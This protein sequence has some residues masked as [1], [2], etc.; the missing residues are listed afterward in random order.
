MR[1]RALLHETETFRE[2]AGDALR[3]GGIGATARAL[4]LCGWPK[5]SEVADVGCGLGATLRLLRERGYRALGFDQSAAMAAEAAA[6]SGCGVRVATAERLPLTDGALDGLVCECLLSL[7]PD[8]DAVLREFFRVLRPGG[9]LLLASVVDRRGDDMD[10]RLD[11][12]GFVVRHTVVLDHE[13]AALAAQLVWRGCGRDEL[14]EPA[15]AGYRQWIAVK[16]ERS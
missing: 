10:R 2:A 4:D 13:V 11:A 8:H 16:A 12:A 3:P 15:G 7:L 9:G 5:G 6:R 1:R 14:P